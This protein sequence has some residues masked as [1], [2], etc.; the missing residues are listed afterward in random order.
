MV[1]SLARLI[2]T[3]ITC[4]P[5]GHPYYRLKIHTTAKWACVGRSSVGWPI[6]YT[7]AALISATELI[8]RYYSNEKLA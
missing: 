8:T 1:Q 4:E 3:K 6:E 5:V 7:S 2:E